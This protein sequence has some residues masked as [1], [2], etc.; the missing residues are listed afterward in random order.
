MRGADYSPVREI[1]Q[2]GRF[3]PTC[4]GQ[5][6]SATTA[7]VSG[8]AV[9]PHMRGADFPFQRQTPHPSRF[10]PTCVGQMSCSATTRT[11]ASRFTP[12]CVGQ[13]FSVRFVA[14]PLFRFTPTCVGQMAATALGTAAIKVHPHM[15][16]ADVT[17]TFIV[18]L[19]V[20]SPPHAW[21]R[22]LYI[23]ANICSVVRFTPT[24]VGQMIAS[25]RFSDTPASVHPH[26]RGADTLH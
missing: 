9:H 5:I 23:R 16:G 12:T 18:Y 14:V 7:L 6:I 10:T 8:D 13:I 21:G 20:G 3:T 15:R 4:V 11:G 25:M 24:C 19:T 22:L 1:P 26:M 17:D 2:H